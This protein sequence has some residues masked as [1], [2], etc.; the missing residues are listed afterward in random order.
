MRPAQSDPTRPMSFVWMLLPVLLIVVL[1]ALVFPGRAEAERNLV[2]APEV[3]VRWW[4]SKLDLGTEASIGVRL[5]MS[6]SDRVSVVMDYV[7]TEPARQTT[8][9]LARISSLRTLAQVRV[10]T[11]KWR[12]YVIAG[13]GGIL[14]DFNDTS[15]AAEGA[16][17]LGGGL[18]MK[19]W[20]RTALFAEGSL[21]LYRS[22]EAFYTTTGALASAGKRTTDHVTSVQLGASFE[23]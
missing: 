2:V 3:G 13:L 20:S 16:V 11:G 23:F 9:E 15:D 6:T 10:L 14:F 22:R 17:T 5:G 7:H 8:G 1:V 21:D 12:P 4:E 19:P 18:E